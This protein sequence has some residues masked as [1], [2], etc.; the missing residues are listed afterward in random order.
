MTGKGE[1]M[2]VIK[3]LSGAGGM[4]TPLDGKYV[5]GFDPD[6][7]DGRGNVTG[8][9]TREH[10]MQFPEAGEAFLF[11][12]TQSTVRPMRPDGKPNRPMTAY[13]INVERVA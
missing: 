12:T 11:W 10:A 5:K 1:T 8:T 13:T 9:P 6:A 3:I 7:F 4:K 2:F